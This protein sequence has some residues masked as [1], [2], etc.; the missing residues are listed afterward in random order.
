[1]NKTITR[2]LALLA[3]LML[4]G[5]ASGKEPQPEQASVY[6]TE[7]VQQTKCMD[8]GTPLADVRVRQALAHAIDMDTVLEALFSGYGE[9]AGDFDGILEP[10]AYDPQLSKDLLAQAGWPSD[11]VLDVVYYHDDPQTEDFLSVV[12]SYWEA[13][14]VKAEFRLLEG[15][16]VSQLWQQPE[17]GKSAVEW[18][19][20]Y[21]AVAALTDGEVYDRFG[22][23]ASS[24]SHTPEIPGLDDL[25]EQA[26]VTRDAQKRAELYGQVRN[27][28]AENSAF[29]PLFHQNC[30]VYTSA[31]LK[32]PEVTHGNDQFAYDKNILNWT[33]DR[34][35]RTLYTDGGPDGF[36]CY[37]VVNPGLYLYQE[38]LFERLIGADSSLNPTQGQL[39]ES[40]T[41]SEDGKTLEIIL[42]DDVVWHDGKPLTPEDVKFTFELYMKCPGANAVLTE[43]LKHLEG[44]GE[45]RGGSAEECT[46]ITVEGN[47]V[48][49]RLEQPQ[50]D[51][52]TVLS[53]WP[54]LPKHCLETADPE[55]LQ[56]DEY[57]KNPI[58]SGPYRVAEVEEGRPCILERWD[59]YRETGDGNIERIS[60]RPSGETD[61]Y[62]VA[63]AQRD[64][65]DY[66][67]GKSTDDAI[68]MEQVEGMTVTE[69]DISYTRCFFV[70]QFAHE[71]RIARQNAETTK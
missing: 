27:L 64:L 65:L 14:G 54:V 5:C 37:P 43:V 32:M 12:G 4:T 30:F 9:K 40:Y 55:N 52:L 42:L 24:N 16:L 45:F 66:A 70:N 31:H 60:M 1:M 34:E 22:S 63:L 26:S 18:D 49:F 15:D 11:Y 68:C 50:A 10:A 44:A 3:L 8:L 7:P 25:L 6:V 20:V 46:G 71:S 41:L 61:G 38:L 29:I 56:Q 47:K 2:I 17:N 48:I 28:L 58:G 36:F 19:L 23:H 39:A 33:T 57:W 13:V 62:L 21:G 35:D 51:L 59:G 53:Q 67:W 69:V